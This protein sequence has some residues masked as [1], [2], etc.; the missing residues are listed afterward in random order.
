MRRVY[1]PC[2]GSLITPRPMVF[3][4]RSE[5]FQRAFSACSFLLNDFESG[6]IWRL[7]YL[8]SL[9]FPTQRRRSRTPFQGV[10]SLLKTR[11]IFTGSPDC[12]ESKSSHRQ[13]IPETDG[14]RRSL[15]SHCRCLCRSGGI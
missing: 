11:L 9:T 4:S 6:V 13:A 3:R 8:N 10:E 14:Q 12:H 1:H 7:T 5:Y 2:F 15:E